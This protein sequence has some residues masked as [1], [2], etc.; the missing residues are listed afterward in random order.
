MA[1]FAEVASPIAAASC[2]QDHHF[3][4]IADDRGDRAKQHTDFVLHGTVD[5]VAAVAEA[6]LTLH[7][8]DVFQSVAYYSAAGRPSSAAVVGTASAC[9]TVAVGLVSCPVASAA[10]ASFQGFVVAYYHYH[11]PY[12]Y[13]SAAAAGNLACRTQGV[14]APTFLKFLGVKMDD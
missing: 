1:S 12:Y 10:A 3:V 7:F 4:Q 5:T 13:A 14:V 2:Q 6:S 8:V 11:T 9:S